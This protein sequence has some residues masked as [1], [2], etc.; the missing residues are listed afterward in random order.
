M[1]CDQL[2]KYEIL[3]KTYKGQYRLPLCLTR[4]FGY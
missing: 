2:E 1:V 3:K 4:V